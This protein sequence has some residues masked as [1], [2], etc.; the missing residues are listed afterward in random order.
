[1]E[2]KL[3]KLLSENK[4]RLVKK[5]LVDDL[6]KHHKID[7]SEK[8]FIDLHIS[9]KVYKKVYER[10]RTDDIKTLTFPYDKQ[11]LISKIH[12]IFDYFKNYEDKKVL[13]YPSAFGSSN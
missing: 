6:M 5:H 13:F 11:N 8:E 4:A 2:N 3:D 7:I 9:K 12:F 10:I 1:M